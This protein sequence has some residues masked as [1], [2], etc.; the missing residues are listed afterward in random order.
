MLLQKGG[1][2]L[3]GKHVINLRE[4][5]LFHQKIRDLSCLSQGLA[6][7]YIVLTMAFTPSITDF[8]SSLILGLLALLW[9]QRKSWLRELLLSLKLLW[10]HPPLAACSADEFQT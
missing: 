9:V 3:S 1:D 5:I 7:F 10:S 6:F 4:H 8:T 2:F